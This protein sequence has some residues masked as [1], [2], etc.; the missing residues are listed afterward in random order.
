MADGENEVWSW[1]ITK[2]KE[3]ASGVFYLLYVNIDIFSRKVIWWDIWTTE[4]GA[5]AKESS[6]AP[7]KKTA[8]TGR[9]RYTLSGAPR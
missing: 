9:A 7:S 3:K 4:T 5:L 1:D 2:L 8:G 6:S